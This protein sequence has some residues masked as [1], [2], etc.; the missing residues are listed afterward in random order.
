MIIKR[1]NPQKAWTEQQKEIAFK[2]LQ[3]KI[4]KSNE[5]GFS[6]ELDIQSYLTQL[7]KRV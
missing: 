2:I 5:K 6:G 1:T 4:L 7:P 3:N